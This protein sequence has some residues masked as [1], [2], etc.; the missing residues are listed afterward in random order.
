MSEFSTFVSK[1]TDSNPIFLI[2]KI[3][4]T[5]LNYYYIKINVNIVFIFY[6]KNHILNN[7][8]F[9]IILWFTVAIILKK[10]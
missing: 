7:S 3:Y 6:L 4:K 2:I 10:I 1:K 8:I 5:L 9:E